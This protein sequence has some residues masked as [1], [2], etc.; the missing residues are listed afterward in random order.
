MQFGCWGKENSSRTQLADTQLRGESRSGKERLLVEPI[1]ITFSC[2]IL[3][4][5]SYRQGKGEPFPRSRELTDGHPGT[6]TR[7][8]SS[9]GLG[10]EEDEAGGWVLLEEEN[11]SP[12]WNSEMQNAHSCCG[13]HLELEMIRLWSS[14]LVCGAPGMLYLEQLLFLIWQ[15]LLDWCLDKGTLNTLSLQRG[16]CGFSLSGVLNNSLV[17][18]AVAQHTE[19]KL[20]LWTFIRH[21][22]E[23]CLS[24]WLHFEIYIVVWNESCSWQWDWKQ[25]QSASPRCLKSQVA[26][27]EI[28]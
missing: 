9:P 6:A 19:V 1:T 25:N 23:S 7:A 5:C 26:V 13:H 4:V 18:G 28:D 21:L 20:P 10:G 12:L 3:L 17:L 22:W 16:G 15:L 8:W 11:F 2:L 14:Q 24:F 27:Q